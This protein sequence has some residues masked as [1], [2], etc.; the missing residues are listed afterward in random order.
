LFSHSF[1]VV[2]VQKVAANHSS[3]LQSYDAI[4]GTREEKRTKGSIGLACNSKSEK[5][6]ELKVT[7]SVG[8]F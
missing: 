4:W 8:K 3:N 6:R 5:Q 7:Q 2:G 1:F